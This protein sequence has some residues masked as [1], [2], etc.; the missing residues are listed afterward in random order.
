MKTLAV[1]PARGG[2]KGVPNKNN[3]YLAGRHI[4]S[5]TMDHCLACRDTEVVV[6]T[7]N[8]E[9]EAAARQLRIRVL[10][11]DPELSTDQARSTLAVVDAVQR[12][13]A[14]GVQF[15]FVAEMS[16]CVPIRPPGCLEKCVETLVRT[17]ADSAIALEEAGTRGP[18]YCVQ[19][20]PTGELQHPWGYV[21]GH[22]R[23]A[24]HIY[25][26]SGA[27]YVVRREIL[28]DPSWGGLPPDDPYRFFGRKRTGV[29]FAKGTTV[30]IDAP[31]DVWLAEF[32]LREM[33][34]G[35]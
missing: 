31:A 12:L 23:E 34:R 28:L 17:R 35:G 8:A 22:R 15:D 10:R 24:A 2:S 29:P 21:L 25:L 20:S 19:L 27:A 9:I 30:D 7:D 1:I 6:T 5:Y 16:A 11:R 32:V 3:L 4:L 33:N 14:E 18:N 26:I 13:A